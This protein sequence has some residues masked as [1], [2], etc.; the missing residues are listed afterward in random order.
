MLMCQ[1]NYSLVVLACV[2]LLLVG[3]GGIGCLLAILWARARARA[4]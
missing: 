4:I 2:N 3:A 1:T